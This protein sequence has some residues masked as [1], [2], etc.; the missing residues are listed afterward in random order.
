MRY[1]VVL[2]IESIETQDYHIKFPASAVPR[3][4]SPLRGPLET[5]DPPPITTPALH[6]TSTPQPMGGRAQ[7]STP[8][9][10]CGMNTPLVIMSVFA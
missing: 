6:Q 5:S 10:P 1:H 9:D 2:N 3:F 4:G 8:G 7:V